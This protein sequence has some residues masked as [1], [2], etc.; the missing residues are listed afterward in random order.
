MVTFRARTPTSLSRRR[1]FKRLAG[2]TV[3]SSLPF[4]GCSAYDAEEGE[5]YEPWNYPRPN[6]SPMY[7][8]VHAALLAASPHNT[9]PWFFAVNDDSMRVEVYAAL[10][11]NLGA[12]DPLSREMYVGIGC[13][14]ENLTL[15]AGY[16]GFDTVIDWSLDTTVLND[17]NLRRVCSIGFVKKAVFSSEKQALFNAIPAR[18]TNRGLYFDGDSPTGLSEAIMDLID[19]DDVELTLLLDDSSKR[20]FRQGTINATIAIN[21]DGK[22]SRASHAWWR[23]THEEIEK[24]RDGLTIDASGLGSTTRFLGKSVGK[25]TAE[26]A[27]DYWLENTRNTQLTGFGFGVLSTTDRNSRE[28][29]LRAGRIWQRIHL[30]LTSQNLA[31]Q[32]LNQMAERQDRE[33]QLGLAPEYSNLLASLTKQKTSTAQML[34]RFGVAWDT[35]LKSPRRPVDWVML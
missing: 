3:V 22:M 31:A 29:Q 26:E 35:A 14:I 15:A 33:E 1:F 23:Q 17:E 4:V 21:H 20:Q 27:G 10:D 30:W 2:L 19:E 28:Q 24:F 18:H 32:P 11:R 13:A 12:M 9:Q 25:P 8:V 5:A 6:E 16:Y 7:S 34:F